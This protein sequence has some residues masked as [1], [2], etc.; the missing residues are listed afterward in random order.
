MPACEKTGSCHCLLCALSTFQSHHY[1]LHKRGVYSELNGETKSLLTPNVGQTNKGLK[2]YGVKGLGLR[3]FRVKGFWGYGVF[4]GL[5]CLWVWGCW[6]FWG[7]LGFG[8]F[9]GV[10]GFGGIWGLRLR[11]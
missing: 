5:G 3:G 6:G 4:G 10:W 7:V 1:R 9:R 8:V 11:G 2:C